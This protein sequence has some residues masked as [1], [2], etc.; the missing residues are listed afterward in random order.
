MILENIDDI[1]QMIAVAALGL[2]RIAFQTL[3]QI[4][5]NQAGSKVRRRGVVEDPPFARSRRGLASIRASLVAR[6]CGDGFEAKIRKIM[7][8]VVSDAEAAGNAK[9]FGVVTTA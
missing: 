4:G 9:A 8:E 1:C 7:D 2:T 5:A 6:K 3:T